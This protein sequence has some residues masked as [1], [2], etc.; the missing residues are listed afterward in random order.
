MWGKAVR[1]ARIRGF[2][3]KLDA[4]WFLIA[5][6][7]VWSLATAYFPGPLP[8]TPAATLV[9]A[10]VVATLGLFASLILHEMAHAEV[11]RRFG[12]K[13]K[14]ITLFLFGGVAELDTEPASGGSEFWIA[15]AG[16]VASLCLALAFWFC[17]EIAALADAPP[18]LEAI[19][20]YLAAVNLM[21]ALFNLL[22]AFPMDGGRVLRAW[23]WSRSGDL[24]AA[25]R[26]ATGIAGIVA[27]GLM[28][29]GL[30]AAF[31][32]QM[33][34]GLWPVL[35]G[36]FLLA[37]S[38]SALAEVETRTALRG[39]RVA[40]LMSR[41]VV[42]VAPDQTLSRLIDAVFLGQGRSFAPVVE[43]GV[44]L[45]YV[46]VQLVRK[47]DREHWDTTTVDDVLESL[48]PDNSV[49]PETP[50]MDLIA[51]I[52]ASGRRKFLVA[53]GG[54]LSGVVTLADVLS[55]LH[56]FREVQSALMTGTAGSSGIRDDP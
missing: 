24:L 6:L 19:L 50:A 5:A 28:A 15:M 43:D 56:S 39:R 52:V 27:Y 33:A 48:G 3:I 36:I 22:P 11:A 46:D 2:D 8:D 12:L 1:I 47:I 54:V 45:G 26:R 31:A 21:L 55:Y 42:S 14:G 25:T 10:A 49:D 13:I 20:S 35:I 38:R 53:R 30:Y 29:L 44:L 40:D 23:L 41:Q 16:P 51:R 18:L 4:S 32:G 7:V 17:A 9:A 34:A 37:T